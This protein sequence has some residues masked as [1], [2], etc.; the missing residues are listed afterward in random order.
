MFGVHNQEGT[1]K[2]NKQSIYFRVT[3]IFTF[4]YFL[5]QQML[6][7]ILPVHI[8]CSFKYSPLL[9]CLFSRSLAT[10]S[11]IQS[12]IDDWKE[13]ARGHFATSTTAHT[14][15]HTESQQSLRTQTEGHFTIFFVMILLPQKTRKQKIR[16][17][18][19]FS[20]TCY[21]Q[22]WQITADSSRSK[23]LIEHF[24][25][26]L[27]GLAPI[28]IHAIY[29]INQNQ[30]GFFCSQLMFWRNRL[31]KKYARQMPR[32]GGFF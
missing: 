31:T 12:A 16:R 13:R 18:V 10:F 9:L 3:M 25:S 11:V 23:C 17:P 19:F 27:A 32:F 7:Q 5:F 6:V 14:H 24:Y 21:M 30:R 22:L 1:I 15:T 2:E 28:P 26:E 4:F 20:H 8:R 29:K